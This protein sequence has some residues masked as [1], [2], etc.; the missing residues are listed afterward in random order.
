MLQHLHDKNSCPT[1]GHTHRRQRIRR[2]HLECIRCGHTHPIIGKP[3]G[4][5]TE[6]L[7]WMGEQKTPEP[8]VI[9]HHAPTISKHKPIS[10]L[11]APL[12][13]PIPPKHGP[14]PKRPGI[15]QRAY[16]FIRR[17]THP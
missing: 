7:P 1:C 14:E 9:K 10:I 3:V 11:T 2:K 13:F 4:C 5:L 6:D 12:P 15:Y 16:N 8:V 17:V